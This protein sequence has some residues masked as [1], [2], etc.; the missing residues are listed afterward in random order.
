MT[1]D[2]LQKVVIE[3]MLPIGAIWILLIVVTVWLLHRQRKQ[4]H[5]APGHRM[6]A[7][8]SLGILLIYSILGNTVVGDL[9]LGSLEQRYADQTILDRDSAEILVVLGGGTS[10]GINGDI[11]LLGSQGNRLLAAARLFHAGKVKTILCTGSPIDGISLGEVASPS[12]QS[13]ILLQQLGI[14]EDAIVQLDGQ[15]T[16]SEIAAVRD[17]CRIHQVKRVAILSSAWHLSRAETLA[18]NAGLVVD[19]IPAGFDTA[20][21]Q[22]SPICL[23][24]SVNG[25]SGQRKG[26]AR[27]SGPVG[28][29][30]NTP[31]GKV[32]PF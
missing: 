21:M 10:V 9:M 8:G 5:P 12:R 20:P 2:Y 11:Q 1:A 4:T 31:P 14:P 13:A 22:L 18:N 25:I 15:H 28:R 7:H 29:S 23:I 19:A 30:I 6:L 32:M 24:P 16:K 17:W 27:V 3:L 26:T